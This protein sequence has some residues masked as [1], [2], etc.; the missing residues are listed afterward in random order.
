MLSRPAAL[1]ILVLMLGWAGV[2][3]AASDS[4]P[5]LGRDKALHFSASL[6]L[7]GGGYGGVALVTDADQRR[8][9]LAGGAGLAL[10]AGAGKEIADH[11]GA[12]DASWRDLTWDVIGTATGLGVAWLIDWLVAGPR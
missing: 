11:F 5:W 8:W 12:G 4:D 1:L 9:R 7:A 10:A 6:V 3:R 2:A